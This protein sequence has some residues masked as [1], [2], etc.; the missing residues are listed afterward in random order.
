MAADITQIIRAAA[1]DGKRFCVAEFL[2]KNFIVGGITVVLNT[3]SNSFE[4]LIIFNELNISYGMDLFSPADNFIGS[5]RVN[6]F[7]KVR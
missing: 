2:N 1:T 6:V 5:V 4:Q 3:E 7:N